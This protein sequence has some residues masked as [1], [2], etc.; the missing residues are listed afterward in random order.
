ML[1]GVEL[2]RR[3]TPPVVDEGI[4]KQQGVA[5]G[6][7]YKVVGALRFLG[8][9]DQDGRPT[10]KA[11]LMKTKGPAFT[12]NLQ[13]IVKEAYS[14]LFERVDIRHS[15]RDDVHN[16]FVTEAGLGAEMATKATRFLAELCALAELPL[17]AG[18]PTTPA[19]APSSARASHQAAASPAPVSLAPPPAMSAGAFG[20]PMVVGVAPSIVLA[21][22][23]ETAQLS[24][25]ELTEL[26]KRIQRA[27]KRAALE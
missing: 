1:Q 16:F 15:S 24:E 21:L 25:D 5:P 23:P 27:V 18:R 3:S 11:R 22:T 13:Q 8:L 7:E 6:N 26:L 10:E 12:L 14:E 19:V 9:I 17:G 4:L 2:M 20:W